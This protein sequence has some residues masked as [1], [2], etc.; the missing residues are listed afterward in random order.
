VTEERDSGIRLLVLRNTWMCH[1]RDIVT[2]NQQHVNVLVVVCGVQL[3]FGL[4]R[5]YRGE[6][7]F[8]HSFLC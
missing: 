5:S 8:N 2:A 1:K 4:R 3:R 7:Y 6:Q